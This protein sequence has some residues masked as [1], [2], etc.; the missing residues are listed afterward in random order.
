MVNV[1]LPIFSAFVLISGA[2]ALAVAPVH[3]VMSRSLSAQV[4]PRQNSGTTDIPFGSNVP[5]CRDPCDK[6][7]STIDSCGKEASKCG[8]T[9][10]NS[11]LVAACINCVVTKR[12]E[13]VTEAEGQDVMNIFVDTCKA[14]S[15]SVKSQTIRKASGNGAVRDLVGL[16]VT[17]AATGALLLA[18]AVLMV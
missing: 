13:N 12:P 7:H 18:G 9:D 2:R 8:C 10:T 4:F 15:F 11:D 6:A 17:T 16:G 14:G 5:E 1:Q 3:D